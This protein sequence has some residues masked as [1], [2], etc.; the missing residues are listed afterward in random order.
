MSDKDRVMKT[1]HTIKSVFRYDS[2]KKIL[3]PL[4]GM[5]IPAGFPS[6]AQDYIE[7]TLDLNEFLISH[8]A[9]TYFVRVE[10]NSMINAGIFPDDLLIVDRSLEPSHNKVV[11]ALVDGELTVK[12][13]K[14]IDGRY[15]LAPE[16]ED[17]EPIEVEEWMDMLVWGV[18]TYVIHKL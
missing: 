16:N 10:G 13:L 15:I 14:V 6:P 1:D 12:R 9:S 4:I 17:Y 3:R 7:G 8:P 11:I 2:K 18:V 5:K